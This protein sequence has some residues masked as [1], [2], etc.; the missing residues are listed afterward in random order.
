MAYVSIISFEIQVYGCWSENMGEK[1]H[2][3]YILLSHGF[4]TA[5]FEIQ[6]YG[7]WSE[8]MEKIHIV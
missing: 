7:C 1:I 3:V 4:C 2:I 8:N 6:V 5:S